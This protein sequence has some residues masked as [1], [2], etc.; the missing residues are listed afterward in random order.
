MTPGKIARLIYPEFRFGHTPLDYALK[1]VE[2]GVGGFCFYGG[3]VSEVYETVKILRSASVTPLIFAADYENG[4]GQWLKEATELP[5]NMAIGASG[6]EALA[7]RKAEIT[8]L[9]ARA[10][11]IDWIFAPVVDLAYRP[12]NPIVNARS[13]GSSRALVTR[14]AGAYLSG[15]SSHNALSCLKHFP[16]HGDTEADSHLTLPTVAKSREAMEQDDLK[17]YRA[18]VR[19]ADSVM[20]GHLNIPALDPDNISSL[21]GK[22]ITGLLRKALNYG[23]CVITDALNMKAISEEVTPGGGRRQ[24]GVTGVKA[25]LAGA[26]ILLVPEDPFKLYD[27]LLRAARDG[28]ITEALADSAI[29]KQETMLLKLSLSRL[30]PP[31]R[32]V[33]YCSGHRSFAAE[34]APQCLAWGYGGGAFRVKAGETVGYYEP[35]TAQKDWKGRIFVEELRRLG[36]NVRPCE[37][38]K[39]QKAVAA[40]FSRPRAYSGSINL[41]AEEKTALQEV[42]KNASDCAFVAF[43]S[44]FVLAGFEKAPSAGLA[45]FCALADFQKAAA[46]VLTEQVEA[47]GVM[48]VDL[49]EG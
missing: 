28:L 25:L 46:R 29:K 31:P 1:L 42:F 34:A 35:L 36:V 8:A 4:A 41:A 26:D 44:P 48:P 13:F 24:A 43:G 17:P 23:G 20:V 6:S 30:S 14:L 19:Q 39:T 22:I 49:H 33:V 37:A 21:S 11:G 3:T 5:T 9:E 10:L 45:A 27:A 32:D 12:G 2:A 7:R 15:L 38:G 18:L 16:G 47:K 40:D